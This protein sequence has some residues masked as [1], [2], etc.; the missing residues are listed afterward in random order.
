[1]FVDYI[2]KHYPERAAAKGIQKYNTG[3]YYPD[4]GNYAI[5]NSKSV[6][7]LGLKYIPLDETLKDTLKKFEELEAEGK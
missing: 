6:R 2:W 1:M 7:D 4:D 3:K 5:D